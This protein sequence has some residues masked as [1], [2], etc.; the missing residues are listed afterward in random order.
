[1]PF[2]TGPPPPSPSPVE[3]EEKSGD[4]YYPVFYPVQIPTCPFSKVGDETCFPR[5]HTPAFA[6]ASAGKLSH[7]GRGVD[8]P[9]G[10][11]GV[12]AEMGM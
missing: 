3:G 11:F 2:E 4:K 5:T 8:W 7:Q 12:F 1:M 9:D 10:V 6:N